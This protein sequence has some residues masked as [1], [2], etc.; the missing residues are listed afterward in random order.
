M[1]ARLM[2]LTRPVRRLGLMLVG[3]MVQHIQAGLRSCRQAV[4]LAKNCTL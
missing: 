1:T 4:L 2:P 3:H